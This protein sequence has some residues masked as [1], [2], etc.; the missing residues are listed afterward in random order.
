MDLS[1][2]ILF[3]VY[4]VN[5]GLLFFILFYKDRPRSWPLFWM[6][7]LLVLW[8]TTELLNLVWLVFLDKNILLFGVQ[9]GLLPTL[10]LAPAFIR[11]VFSLFDKWKRLA[12]WQKFLWY[13]PAIIMSFFVF[14]PYNVKELVLGQAGRFF[15]V[16]GEIYWLL[17][18]YFVA[19]FGYGLYFLAKNRQCCGPIIRRQINYIFLGTALTAIAGLVFSI[20]SPILGVYN[21]YYL[22]VNSTI[23]FTIISTYALFRY[24]FFNLKI[25]FYQL[26]INFS[27]L[28]ILG[29]V[30]Y[31]FYIFF[32]DLFKIDF[33]DIQTISFLLLVLGLSAPFLLKI[34]DRLLLLLF[35]N[36]VNDIKVSTD[37]I[38]QILRS[39]RDLEILLSR[40]AKEIDKVVDYREI[41]IYL[42]KKKEPKIFYQVFPVGE[43]LIDG[44]KSQLIEYLSEKK[45][46]ANLAEIE[47]FFSNKALMAEM[48]DGQI[49][50]AL[51][52]FYNK[53]LLGVLMLDN[54]AKL[55]SVQELQFLEELNKYLDIAVGS[56]LLYQQDMA[57]KE[58]C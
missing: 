8:Q 28:F 36:P 4:L 2:L 31:V 34:V 40:L 9:A 18:V 37:K 51:P 47:Y 42:A 44:T 43:R 7:L 56:L 32:R 52:I 21:L 35:I 19:L 24:R 46:M 55:L 41:F 29:Y 10:Y 54:Y 14:T 48:K 6:L 49:D 1:A 39:S 12:Y 50:I 58:Q 20:I 5:V 30:Y 27:R 33:N 11:L 16:T 17:A 26:L 38:A 15:Y 45:K 22:G 25:S 57:G 13:L 53:Q 3:C 23:F